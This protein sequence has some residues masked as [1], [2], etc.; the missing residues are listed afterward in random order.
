MTQRTARLVLAGA[1][2]FGAALRFYP[3]QVRFM[4]PDQ[5]LLPA[6]A[7]YPLAGEGLQA[8]GKIAAHFDG[9]DPDV[10]AADV[11]YEPIDANF[12]PLRGFAHV[13]AP[14]PDITVWWVAKAPPRAVP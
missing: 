8:R 7:T 9:I 4:H 11:A 3:L 12:V 6:L 5:E 13:R 14:G 2:V 1:I 10:T